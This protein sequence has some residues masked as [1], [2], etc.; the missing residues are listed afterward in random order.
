MLKERLL[1]DLSPAFTA[2]VSFLDRRY[3]YMTV[4]ADAHFTDVCGVSSI[5]CFLLTEIDPYKLSE[6]D[7]VSASGDRY[8]SYVLSKL[9]HRAPV[10]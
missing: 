9:R 2:A 1:E 10:R 8:S 6:N 5:E 3:A 7:I 4:N